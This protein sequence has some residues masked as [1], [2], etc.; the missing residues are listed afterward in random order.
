TSAIELIPL[1]NSLP[2]W[3]AYVFAMLILYGALRRAQELAGSTAGVTAK[4]EP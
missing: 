1:F 2:T 3:I 4:T